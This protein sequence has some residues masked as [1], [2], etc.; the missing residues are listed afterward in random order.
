MPIVKLGRFE[1]KSLLGKGAMGEVFRAHDPVLDRNVA[2]KIIRFPKDLTPEKL[3][4]LKKEFLKEAQLAA[5]ISHKGI[6]Q[7][8]D[9]GE[10]DGLPFVVLE[11]ISGNLLSDFLKQKKGLEFEFIKNIYQELLSAMAFA[12]KAGIIHL[13]LKPANII[14]EKNGHPKIMD[15]GIA[16]SIS[17]LWEKNIQITGTPRFMAPEQI[18]GGA[19][20]QRTDIF[21]LGIIFYL[22]ISGRLPFPHTDFEKLR[23]AITKESHPPLQ[24]HESDLPKAYYDFVNTALAK[25]PSDRFENAASMLE[26]FNRCSEKKGGKKKSNSQDKEKAGERQEILNFIL[27]RIKRKG[28]FPAISQYVSEVIAAAKSEDSSAHGIAR[29]ILKDI[30]MTN[31]VLRIANSIYYKG[32]ASEV[33]TISRAVVVLGVDVILSL[34]STVGIFE[35][36]SKKS[37]SPALQAL[38]IEAT[39]SS[40]MAQEFA[41]HMGLK[42]PEE[43]LICSMMQYLGRLVVSFY[44]SEEQR[45]I[46]DLMKQGEKDEE[47][48][49]RQV[50][51]LSCTELGQAIA[52]SWNLPELLQSGMVKINPKNKGP[53]KDGV[54]TLQC[55]TSYSSDLSKASMITDKQERRAALKSLTRKF[56]DLIPVKI[57]DLEKIADDSIEK[58]NDFSGFM[59]TSM[60]K[61]GIKP[62]KDAES[63][64]KSIP[65][66]EVCDETVQM[67][68]PENNENRQ[69][70]EEK[71]ASAN[72]INSNSDNKLKQIMERQKILTRT[73]SDI[74]TSITNKLSI[75]DIIMMA[76]EGMY[77]GLEMR[78]VL[79][80]MVSPKR[81]NLSFKFGLGPE[82]PLLAKAFNFS[83]LSKKEPPV[84]SVKEKKEYVIHNINQDNGGT[85]KFH[86][87]FQALNATSIII[88]PLMVKN[89]SMGLF[90]SMRIKGQESLTE[91]DI[92]NM[93]M[94]VS[95]VGL[96]FY[97][98]MMSK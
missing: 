56:K 96:G 95:Q 28:D 42:Q 76:L 97:Q 6:V 3:S 16:K 22:L 60:A 34:T 41:N 70:A 2:I 13:D 54:E 12:H 11:L 32:L 51:R 48:A 92:Q 72:E 9:I 43:S 49:F 20:D 98:S 55:I 89:I 82:I 85:S 58:A 59:K 50:M 84:H 80:A 61:L 65:S 37:D 44:F 75:N 33:T 62:K 29:S 94:L 83:M 5:A 10:Q 25:K 1:I 69:R 77:R 36:F 31:T 45:A 21:S 66:A 26:A 17:D 7:V 19:L 8:Y 4:G 38:V 57:K 78:N 35:H 88:F 30:S 93:R 91:M 64:K 86:K 53:L 90:L 81:D 24:S 15:F 68:F 63:D 40:L 74:T 46:D 71:I 39:L 47:E 87:I 14:I 73:I 52:E 27:Q 18:T 67:P 23:H 79:L